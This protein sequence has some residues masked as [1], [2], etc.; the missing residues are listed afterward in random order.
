VCVCVCPVQECAV[1]AVVTNRFVFVLG[2]NDNYTR[3]ELPDTEVGGATMLQ[4]AN[5]P[6]TVGT[7]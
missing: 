7:A 3:L 2:S 5:N 4:N 1:L 6:L